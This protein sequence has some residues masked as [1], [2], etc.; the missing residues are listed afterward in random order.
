L[1]QS[2]SKLFPTLRKIR[3]YDR[4]ALTE[5]EEFHQIYKLD[6]VDIPSNRQIVR[7]DRPDRI[8]KTEAGKFRA[9]IQEVK[10]LHTKAS[11]SNCTVS[12]ERMK[13][14]VDY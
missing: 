6:V 9:I 3:W 8:Y 14:L 13:Y 4:T 11:R 2:P 7:L 1:Q 10:M 12:I 5:A